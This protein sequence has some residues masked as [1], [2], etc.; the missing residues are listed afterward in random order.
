LLFIVLHLVSSVLS[1]TKGHRTV[2]VVANSWEDCFR[3][4]LFCVVLSLLL[5]H[6]P[7]TLYVDVF[8]VTLP[9]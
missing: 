9:R 8:T 3:C 5:L 1:R 4:D 6:L 7:L 2:V